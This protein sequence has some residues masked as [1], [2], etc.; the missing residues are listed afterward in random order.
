MIQQLQKTA[1]EHYQYVPHVSGLDVIKDENVNIAIHERSMDDELNTFLKQLTNS[2]FSSL[3]T[4][5]NIID[6]DALFDTHFKIYQSV[7]SPGYQKLKNDIK[8]LI[9]LF[10][11]ICNASSVK[12]FFGIIN[13]DMCKRF[14]VDI[15][16]LRMIC[17]Y[18][19]QG[20]LW[21]TEDNINTRAL[22]NGGSNE[23]IVLRQADI[24]Q[25]DTKDVAILKGALYPNCTTGGVVHRSP[26]I[27]SGNQKRIMLRVDSNSLLDSIV[28]K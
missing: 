17:T 12:V 11:E 18:E 6:F 25:L 26:A 9:T 14:H 21:L 20:T 19:G 3:N 4:S 5:L 22:N 8:H 7:A 1:I 27:E 10:S 23:A 13:T 24:K 15:Y 2:N 28:S 16:N